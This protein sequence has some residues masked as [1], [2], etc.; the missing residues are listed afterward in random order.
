MNIL[1]NVTYVLPRCVTPTEVS[2][3]YAAAGYVYKHKAI[4]FIQ[5]TLIF[6]ANFISL[7]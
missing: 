3:L 2:G 1:Y 6:N 5:F 4:K 7:E